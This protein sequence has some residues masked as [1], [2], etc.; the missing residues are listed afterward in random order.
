MTGRRAFL[1]AILASL[2]GLMSGCGAA[3][4]PPSRPAPPPPRPLQ[5][6]RLDALLPLAGLEW[7]ILVEP[8]QIASIPWLIPPIGM[9]VS[10]DRFARFAAST[11]L[12]L[13]QIPEAIVAS[14]AAEEGETTAYLV[15]HGGDAVAIERA[16]RRRLTGSERRS[17]DRP[18]VVRVSGKIGG[19]SHAFAAMGPDVVCFQQGGS[20]ARGPARIATLYATGKLLRSPT[21]LAEEP[22]RSLAQRFGPAPARAFAVGPFEGELAR[23]A[24]G[25][26][27]AATAIGAAARPSAREGIALGVAVAGDFSNSGEPA[28][29]EL[30]AAWDDLAK[31]SFGHL[32]GLDA[33]VTAPLATHSDDA[34][35]IAVEL[36]PG[37]LAKGLADA[38][39]NQIADIMR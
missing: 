26:L 35:A 22:L 28:E 39:R 5:T 19:A 38:T 6:S 31:G 12:D 24:R 33:P 14:Y 25:L 8:R 30:L 17:V 29:R 11:G 2:G 23:G 13:R 9:I 16:F 4:P 18:G 32:L 3:E 1:G 21:A 36:D 10:E 37:R 15:R 7:L 20:A 34:V 27:A